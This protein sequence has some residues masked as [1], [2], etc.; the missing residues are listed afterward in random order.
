M[1]YE[2]FFGISLI[3]FEFMLMMRRFVLVY[4]ILD[5][6][7]GSC[8]IKFGVC[9]MGR[10]YVVFIE[11][12]YKVVLENWGLINEW[13]GLMRVVIIKLMWSM[14]VRLGMMRCEFFFLGKVRI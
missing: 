4:V 8:R 10:N 9:M 6:N 11:L 7:I 1:V 5:L 12:F 2:K 13:N 3:N 14:L